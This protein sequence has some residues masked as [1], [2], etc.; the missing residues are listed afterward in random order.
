MKGRKGTWTMNM[1][2]VLLYNLDSPKG[3]KIRRMCLP[4]GL[5]ARLV[6]ER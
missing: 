1:P 5:R 2:L 4:L 6:E 3:A